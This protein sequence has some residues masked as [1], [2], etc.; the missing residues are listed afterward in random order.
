MKLTLLAKDGKSG[1][2]DC[3]SVYVADTGE[4]VVQGLELTESEMPSLQNPLNG[5]TA[6]RIDPTIVIEAVEQYRRSA[7]P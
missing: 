2:K 3:P 4:L 7:A 1:V 6:V 5:E